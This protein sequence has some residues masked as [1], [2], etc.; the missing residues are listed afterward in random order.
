MPVG[1]VDGGL[2]GSMSVSFSKSKHSV[3]IST[4]GIGMSKATIWL[5]RRLQ[6]FDQAMAIDAV[7]PL[8]LIAINWSGRS[9]CVNCG[10]RL[11]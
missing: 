1:I 11:I 3:N 2:S 7:T 6:G 9:P 4:Q 10:S 5:S 8:Q